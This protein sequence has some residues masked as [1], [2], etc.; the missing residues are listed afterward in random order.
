MS[1]TKQLVVLVK[2]F[3]QIDEEASAILRDPTGEIT[4]TVHSRVIEKYPY[5]QDGCVLVLEDV[6]SLSEATKSH[7]LIITDLNVKNVFPQFYAPPEGTRL[8]KRFEH[9]NVC[10]S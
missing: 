7:H 5:I 8:P 6:A 3:Q 4:A 9:L 2:L 1:K 10:F